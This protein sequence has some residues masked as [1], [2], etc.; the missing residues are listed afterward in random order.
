MS[1]RTLVTVFVNLWQIEGGFYTAL[2][3]SFNAE[4]SKDYLAATTRL[5][6]EAAIEGIRD[7]G[8]DKDWVFPELEMGQAA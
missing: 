5:S 1:R 2:A 3:W 8:L 4:G 7:L 6:P